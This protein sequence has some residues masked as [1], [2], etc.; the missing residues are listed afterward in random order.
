ME[1]RTHSLHLRADPDAVFAYLSE[2]RNMPRWAVNFCRS[3]K[4]EG[5]FTRL[6]TPGGDLFFELKVDSG[7]GVID[8]VGGPSTAALRRWHSRVVPAPGGGALFLFTAVRQP[9]EDLASFEGQCALL[10]EELEH[11]RLEV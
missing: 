11:I 10:H 9:D 6:E 8:F 4:R 2:I 1:T 5:G 7:T 3:V